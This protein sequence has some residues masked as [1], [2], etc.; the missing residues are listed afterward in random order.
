MNKKLYIIPGFGENTNG[1]SYRAIAEIASRK[2]YKVIKKHPNW[3]KPLSGQVFK[4]TDQDTIFGFSLGAALGYMIAQ[5]FPCKRI[6]LASM[7]PF[8]YFSRREFEE[9]VGTEVARD[10]EKIK[11]KKPFAKIFTLY[12]AKE[13]IKGDIVIPNTGHELTISYIQEIGRLL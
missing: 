2:G 4:V 10:L 3:K 6:I 13:N 5:Q 8:P 7:T 1:G 9:I 12:G 11:W